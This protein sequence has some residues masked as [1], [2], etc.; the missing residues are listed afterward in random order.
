[1]AIFKFCHIL[2]ICGKAKVKYQIVFATYGSHMSDD[3]LPTCGSRFCYLFAICGQSV[4]YWMA[5]IW[6]ICGIF[7]RVNIKVLNNRH[8]SEWKLFNLVYRYIVKRN[9]KR[10][11]IIWNP[12]APRLKWRK[13][14][15]CIGLDF[16]TFSTFYLRLSCPDVLS[17]AC[18][19]VFGESCTR[20]M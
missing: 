9:A 10:F 7:S 2:V 6:P 8:L 12:K 15:I 13:F 1:M 17:T 3:A 20:I 16:N 4:A 5:H 19:A 14:K 18:Y 11:P